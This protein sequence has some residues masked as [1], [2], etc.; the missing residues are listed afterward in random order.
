MPTCSQIRVFDIQSEGS[1]SW[2]QTQS[3]VTICG[4][5]GECVGVHLLQTQKWVKEE[6]RSFQELAK[7][8]K[9]ENR[10]HRQFSLSMKNYKRF[11]NCEGRYSNLVKW[12]VL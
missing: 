11:S 3:E 4:G 1:L 9:K 5:G 7:T 6:G 10:G 8:E 2:I 12:K